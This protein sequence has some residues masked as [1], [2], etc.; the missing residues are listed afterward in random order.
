MKVIQLQLINLC[1]EHIPTVIL[2]AVIWGKF[3]SYVGNELQSTAC[4]IYFARKATS[5]C[6]MISWHHSDWSV[7]S[8]WIYILLVVL[9]CYKLYWP[10]NIGIILYC[11]GNSQWC[12]HNTQSKSYRLFKTQSR[13]QQAAWLILENNEKIYLS[14]NLPI[15]LW[16]TPKVNNVNSVES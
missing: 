1:N 6:N 9:G 11:I 15:Q 10:V 7:A 4:V 5:S 3:F 16:P 2:C 8:L 12:I 14:I 13:V